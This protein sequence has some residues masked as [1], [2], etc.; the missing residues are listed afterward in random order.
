MTKC[1][2]TTI[3]T[4]NTIH[5]VMIIII[6]SLLRNFLL[7]LNLFLLNIFLTIF[8]YFTIFLIL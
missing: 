1:N 6:I 3:M 8:E 2:M 7:T 5:L 4:N